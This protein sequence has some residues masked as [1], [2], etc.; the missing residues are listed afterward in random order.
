MWSSRYLC[1]DNRGKWR[2]NF[3][4]VLAHCLRVDAPGRA[5][6]QALAPERRHY[7]VLKPK[8]SAF[9]ATPLDALLAYLKTK[10][11]I[12]AGLTTSAC[13]LLLIKIFRAGNSHGLTS[14]LHLTADGITIFA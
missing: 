10:V 11:V 3:A 14:L 1:H 8:H 4:T 7:I 5:M 13:V 9:Y 12:P 2:S 6:A